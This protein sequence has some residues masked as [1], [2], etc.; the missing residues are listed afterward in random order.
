MFSK[1]RTEKETLLYELNTQR[2]NYEKE[3]INKTGEIKRY[4]TQINII[5]KEKNDL[6][7]I[8]NEYSEY[9]LYYTEN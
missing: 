8:K 1:T 3:L 7:D 6:D 2:D 5:S 9:I 4:Q